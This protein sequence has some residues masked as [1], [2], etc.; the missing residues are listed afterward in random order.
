MNAN[1][2]PN[3]SRGSA[4]GLLWIG[5]LLGAYVLSTGLTQKMVDVGVMSVE[6]MHIYEPLWALCQWSP[7]LES[8]LCWYVFRVWQCSC[9]LH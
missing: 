9:L 8:L 7:F 5:I 1:H 6:V 4:H 3:P 2:Q